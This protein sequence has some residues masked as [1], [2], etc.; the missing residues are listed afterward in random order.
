IFSMEYPAPS[1][2]FKALAIEMISDDDPEI[3]APAGASEFV[4][5]RNPVEGAKKSTSTAGRG[6]RYLRASRSAVREGNRSS[7]PWSGLFGS[8]AGKSRGSITHSGY[9]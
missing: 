3:P 2:L 7:I 9:R 4:V 8:S 6:R 5:M 1:H